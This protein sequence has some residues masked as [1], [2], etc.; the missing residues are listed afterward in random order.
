[1]PF[2]EA[3]QKLEASVVAMEQ[4]D[5]PL[6]MLL[7]RYEEGTRLAAMCQAKLAEADLKIK[8]LEQNAAGELSLKPLTPDLEQLD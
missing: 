4:D 2:E 8:Q 3:L 7:A 1:L 6:E 5:L